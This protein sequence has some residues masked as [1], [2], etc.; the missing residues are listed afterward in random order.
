MRIA[1]VALSPIGRDGRVLRTAR[2]LAQSG[3][4]V[5]VLGYGPKPLSCAGQFHTLGE[6]PGRIQHWAWV[7]AGYVPSGLSRRLGQ[8]LTALRPLHRRSQ[9]LLCAIRPEVIHAHDWPALPIAIWGKQTTGARIVYDSHEFAREEHG[10]SWLWRV[11][12]RPHVCAIEAVGVH[13]ADRV[14]T[15]SPGIARLLAEIYPLAE[16]PLVVLNVPEYRSV[17]THPVGERVELLYHGLLTRGRG[18]ETLILAMAEIRRPVRLVLRGHGASG[19]VSGLRRLAALHAAPE[20]IVFEPAVPLESVVES[21][22]R[23]D[24][25]VFTPP[26]A[27]SQIRYML[28]NKLFEYLMAGLMVVFSHAEDVAEIVHRYGCGKILSD[29]RPSHLATAIDALSLEEIRQYKRSALNSARSLCWDRE[30]AKLTKL[31]ADMM[32]SQ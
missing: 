26:L 4:E 21:A 31:Y 9:K 18:I 13:Y 27:T 3:H 29:V 20:T 23:S 1:A 15:V 19:Y 24:I 22:A 30:Q 8:A 10:E 2:A 17:E 25:G 32:K 28:P 12:C 6:P 16:S 14:L 7:L 11:L 5:H